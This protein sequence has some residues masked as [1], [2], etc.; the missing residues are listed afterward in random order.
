MVTAA[1]AAATATAVVGWL[2]FFLF[3]SRYRHGRC[4]VVVVAIHL[5]FMHCSSPTI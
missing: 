5:H 2:S 1:I 4:V 3:L